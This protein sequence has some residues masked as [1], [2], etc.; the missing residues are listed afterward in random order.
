VSHDAPDEAPTGLGR[1]DPVY[2]RLVALRSVA[3]LT[4]VEARGPAR[5]TAD[6]HWAYARS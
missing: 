2:A 4:Q 6:R 3:G 5:R 1:D